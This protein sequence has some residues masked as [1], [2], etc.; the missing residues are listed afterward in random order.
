MFSNVRLQ[1]R[2][3][4]E[5]VAEIQKL[6]AEFWRNISI[7]TPYEQGMVSELLNRTRAEYRGMIEGGAIGEFN[8]AIQEYQSAQAPIW[9]GQGRMKSILG[10]L[11]RLKNEMELVEMRA[12]QVLSGDNPAGELEA[13]RQEAAQSGDKH[14][15]RASLEVTRGALSKIP[16]DH[17]D[18]M[19]VNRLA[20][21]AGRELEELR[22]S[23]G[24]KAALGRG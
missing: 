9:T 1:V 24:I 23:D 17:P 20:K 18:R 4:R 7:M 10:I 19:K 6:D 8:A 12:N 2:T 16:A 11:S 15:I 21:E 14:K 22:T 3:W 13:L 5:A